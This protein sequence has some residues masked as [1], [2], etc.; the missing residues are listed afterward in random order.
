MFPKKIVMGQLNRLIATNKN[1]NWVHNLINTTNNKLTQF[2]M[3]V[4]VQVENGGKVF[5]K[6]KFQATNDKVQRGLKF[7][8]F[9][10]RGRGPF[11]KKFPM[12]SQAIPIVFP[13]TF[14][15]APCF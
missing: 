10:F 2:I 3:G 8:S 1:E 7:F 15:L 5:W 6:Q 11:F 4:L 13:K 9:G 12:Y 14:P